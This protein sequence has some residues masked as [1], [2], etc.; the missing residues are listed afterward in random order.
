MESPQFDKDQH[1]RETHA[2]MIVGGVVI[3]LGVGGGLVWVI[4]GRTAAITAVGC[5]LA[6]FALLGLLWLLLTL[7]ERWVK[8]EGS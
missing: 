7:I 2:R 8:G 4:Y 5:L 6:A 1:Q 3:L